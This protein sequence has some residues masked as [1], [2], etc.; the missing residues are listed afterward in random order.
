MLIRAGGNTFYANGGN[1]TNTSWVQMTAAVTVYLNAGQTAS[2]MGYMGGN[3][4]GH[5]VGGP[6]ATYMFTAFTGALI[7]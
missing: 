3:P 2:L 4:P 6:S 5:F 7:H 1:T